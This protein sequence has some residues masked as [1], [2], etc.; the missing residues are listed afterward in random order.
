MS[1]PSGSAEPPNSGPQ[2]PWAVQRNSGGPP[3]WAIVAVALVAVL[4]IIVGAT[5]YFTRSSSDGGSVF[6][7]AQTRTSGAGAAITS[8]A[9]NRANLASAADTGPVGIVTD[10]PTC[11][12]WTGANDALVAAEQN[13]WTQRDPSTPATAWT[14]NQKTAYEAVA[15]AMRSAADQA[16]S[17]AKQTRHRVIRELYEQT[18]AYLTA[19]ADGVAAYVPAN[20][21]LAETATATATALTSICEAITNGS[22][23]A[24]AGLIP[25]AADPTA[26]TASA[27][28]PT[29]FF[30]PPTDP[31]CAQWHSLVANYTTAFAQWRGTDQK[32][33]A[34]D[35]NPAQRAIND[36]VAPRMVAFADDAETL[37]KGTSNGVFRDF[38]TLAGE[39]R[40]AFAAALPTYTPA[41]G[42]LTG[43]ASAATGAIDSACLATEG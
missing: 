9:P 12:A 14:A 27:G 21:A 37:A 2:Q 10:E 7:N 25:P 4:G 16:V 33:A 42:A 29:R 13:G 31:V 38:A 18:T 24:R 28:P 40:R 8:S 34:A 32:V 11:A 5:L 17:L 39:Y 23:T 1:E 15:L 35:W 36:A 20:D 22:A 3:Q 6:S 43:A 30:Q 41:D 19:Y 26:S